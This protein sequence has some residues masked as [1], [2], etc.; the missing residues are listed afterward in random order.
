MGRYARHVGKGMTQ[1]YITINGKIRHYVAPVG[2]AQTDSVERLCRRCG[3]HVCSC[4]PLRDGWG[5]RLANERSK[6]CE[7][8]V[9]ASGVCS[10]PT[11][12]RN[13]VCSRRWKIVR[14]AP[15]H[16]VLGSNMTEVNEDV[17]EDLVTIYPLKWEY[18][19]GEE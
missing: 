1:K 2:G 13:R 18:V 5:V 7:Q 8:Q 6:A 4:P 3:Y 17:A 16:R 10:K 14:N 19:Y 12:T 11:H 15:R 9:A